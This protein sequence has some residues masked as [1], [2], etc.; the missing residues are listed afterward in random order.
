MLA[1]FL[2]VGFPV[3]LGAGFG[4][5][6]MVGQA[7]GKGSRL[8]ERSGAYLYPVLLAIP[9]IAC[10]VPAWR[11]GGLEALGFALPRLGTLG[12]W[13]VVL[14]GSLLGVAIGAAL[15]YNELAVGTLVQRM[16]DRR[17]GITR[18]L[19]GRSREFAAE[20]RQG[21]LASILTISIFV[22]IAEE[23][24]WR[25]FLPA[26]LKQRFGL[27]LVLAG[28]LAA[29]S[30]GINHYY[31]GLR[32]VFLKGLSGAVWIVLFLATGSLLIPCVSHYTF[33]VLAWRRIR[34]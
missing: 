7:L 15:F 25:G 24:L 21:S 22:V 6:F 30:F 20:Q 3:V 9:L 5:V 16:V 14:V 33:E 28:F 29:L 27:S 23:V 31:F 34:G 17:R 18:A 11:Q 19:E 26:F 2:T 12:T 1:F 32:N 13:T 10:L 4:L 8:L